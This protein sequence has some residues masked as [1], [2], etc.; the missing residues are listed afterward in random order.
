MHGRADWT[1][2]FTRRVLAMHA[3][4]RLMLEPGI[5]DRAGFV[6][7]DANPVHFPP[8]RDLIFA[9]HRN[10]VLGLARDRAR[11]ATNA[12]AEIDHHSPGVTAIFEFIWMI[13]RL[14]MRGFFFGSRDL[15]WMGDKFR[16]RS[17]SQKIT[18]FHRVMMLCS[19]E[20]MFV[21]G[22]ANR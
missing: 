6:G 17:A 19:R 9:N 2:Q 13:Q 14:V 16:E 3:W 7:V 5:V 21:A 11:A 18:S 8:A 15:F 20:Q 1:D 12:G 22:L 10:V 4:H